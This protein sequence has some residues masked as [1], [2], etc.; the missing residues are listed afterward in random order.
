M[1][2]NINKN[3]RLLESANSISVFPDLGLDDRTAYSV[4]P[5]PV[6]CGAK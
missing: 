3:S 6:D 2:P 5:P 4:S 1:T